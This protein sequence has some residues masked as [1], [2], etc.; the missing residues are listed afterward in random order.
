MLQFEKNISERSEIYQEEQ[1]FTQRQITLPPVKKRQ[2]PDS[3][4]PGHYCL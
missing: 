2:C 4:E 1:F 3:Y